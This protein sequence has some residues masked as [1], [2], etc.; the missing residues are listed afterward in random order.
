MHQIAWACISMNCVSRLERAL[1]VWVLALRTHWSR[2][3]LRGMLPPQPNLGT[4]SV[5][6]SL[7]PIWSHFASS[8]DSEL[9]RIS[10]C[11]VCLPDFGP[12]FSARQMYGFEPLLAKSGASD[13]CPSSSSGLT[14][15]ILIGFNQHH[16]HNHPRHHQLPR[17]SSSQFSLSSSFSSSSLS[18]SYLSSSSLSSKSSLSSNFYDQNHPHHPRHDVKLV[19]I[20]RQIPI[21]AGEAI[22]D[23][24]VPKISTRSTL[25]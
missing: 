11:C 6:A 2:H 9:A 21:P 25:R 15:I 3:L 14:S 1:S 13:D 10:L 7:C 16:P 17:S 23:A 5:T 8:T 4:F 18:S 19:T 12:I 20:P 24:V 22:S